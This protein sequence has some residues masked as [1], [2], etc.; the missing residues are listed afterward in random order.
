VDHH[1]LLGRQRQ[2]RALRRRKARGVTNRVT[3]LL[4]LVRNEADLREPCNS[5]SM[6]TFLL[7]PWRLVCCLHPPWWLFKPVRSG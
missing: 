7:W 1:E 5:V 3:T 2:E 4:T 6:H